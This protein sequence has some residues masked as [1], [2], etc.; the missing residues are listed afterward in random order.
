MN[1]KIHIASVHQ[2]KTHLIVVFVTVSIEGNDSTILHESVHERIKLLKCDICDYSYSQKS[3]M[4][5][6]VS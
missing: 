4:N 2:G 1:L 6:H 5:T 3:N